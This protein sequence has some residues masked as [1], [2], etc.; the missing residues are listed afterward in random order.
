MNHRYAGRG[1]VEATKWKHSV[2]AALSAADDI[3][4]KQRDKERGIAAAERRRKWREKAA[5][6]SA[7]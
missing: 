6:E 5:R 4:R 1:I 3:F 2:N 7:T